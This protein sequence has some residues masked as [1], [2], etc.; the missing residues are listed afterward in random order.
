MAVTTPKGYI[1]FDC[2][3]SNIKLFRD[4]VDAATAAAGAN[5]ADDII[6]EFYKDIVRAHD[7]KLVFKRVIWPKEVTPPAT[8][9]S[10]V[11]WL[12]FKNASNAIFAIYQ[13]SLKNILS[14]DDEMLLLRFFADLLKD[15]AVAKIKLPMGGAK[16]MIYRIIKDVFPQ[17]FKTQTL[18]ALLTILKG[19]WGFAD[20]PDPAAGEVITQGIS[21]SGDHKFKLPDEL[22]VMKLIFRDSG[23]NATEVFDD[24]FNLH[25]EKSKNKRDIAVEQLNEEMVINVLNGIAIGSGPAGQKLFIRG[26]ESSLDPA[27]NPNKGHLCLC[28]VDYEPDFLSK[29]NGVE[30]NKLSFN[31]STNRIKDDHFLCNVGILLKDENIGSQFSNILCDMRSLPENGGFGVSRNP[32]V[33]GKYGN[34]EGM[35]M[36]GYTPPGKRGGA[37]NNQ[38]NPNFI[39][40]FIMGIAG[41]GTKNERLLA[42]LN[43]VMTPIAHAE[44]L[45]SLTLKSWGDANQ[46]LYIISHVLYLAFR[47]LQNVL[48]GRAGPHPDAEGPPPSLH[49]FFMHTLS[50]C[51]IITCDSVLARTAVALKIPVVYQTGLVVSCINFTQSDPYN[52]ALCAFNSQRGKLLGIMD[53]VKFYLAKCGGFNSNLVDSDGI[54]SPILGN[55]DWFNFNIIR[56]RIATAI[57]THITET[58]NLEPPP[59]QITHT[60]DSFQPLIKSLEKIGALYKI[61]IVTHTRNRVHDGAERHYYNLDYLRA[62]LLVLSVGDKPF[63]VR[64][65]RCKTEPEAIAHIDY[66]QCLAAV[67]VLSPPPPPVSP[68][69]QSVPLPLPATGATAGMTQAFSPLHSAPLHSERYV[70]LLP[71]PTPPPTRPVTRSMAAVAAGK[72]NNNNDQYKTK[73]LPK[74]QIKQIIE[75]NIIKNEQIKSLS[76]PRSSSS[77]GGKRQNRV[78]QIGG[79]TINSD[80]IF[81]LLGS[82]YITENTDQPYVTLNIDGI[83]SLQ[84][85]INPEQPPYPNI[86]FL[87]VPFVHF[88]LLALLGSVDIDI[89]RILLR[90]LGSDEFDVDLQSIYDIVCEYISTLKKI[91]EDRTY[92]VNLSRFYSKMR[93]QRVETETAD[94]TVEAAVRGAAS[95]VAA[96]E[97]AGDVGRVEGGMLGVVV[98]KVHEILT[99]VAAEDRRDVEIV[100]MLLSELVNPEHEDAV[101]KQLCRLLS[102]GPVSEEA[103]T[104]KQI[105]TA[106]SISIGRPVIVEEGTRSAF[107][108]VPMH[109][110]VSGSASSHRADG[111]AN[112]GSPPDGHLDQSMSQS[113]DYTYTQP[114]ARF[115][116]PPES[117][118][119]SHASVSP[120]RSLETPEKLE[121]GIDYSLVL[122]KLYGFIIR[123]QYLKYAIMAGEGEDGDDM[124]DTGP[125]SQSLIAVLIYMKSNI[126]KTVLLNPLGIEG[127]NELCISQLERIV[128]SEAGILQEMQGL[129]RSDEDELERTEYNTYLREIKEFVAHIQKECK[130]AVD[131]GVDKSKI[132]FTFIRPIFSEIKRGQKGHR[133]PSSSP[134]PSSSSGQG[135]GPPS[136][137]SSPSSPSKPPAKKKGSG[138]A[139]AVDDTAAYAGG[140]GSC[141][142]TKRTKKYKRTPNKRNKTI[143]NKFK[144]KSSLRNTIKRRKT[145]QRK[146]SRR[147]NQ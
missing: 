118:V 10:F 103:I 136:S 95:V 123:G 48:R 19:G 52:I 42:L 49:F 100:N 20:P 56:A 138:A 3:E 54:P 29:W 8:H 91:Y 102:L 80:D 134:P 144:T 47:L 13:L 104:I 110:L 1:L 53:A 74:K 129:S 27:T 124:A 40:L 11:V 77:G 90:Y 87:D 2:A 120:P 125:D 21:S 147:R 130:I 137:P 81:A 72:I 36:L 146:N 18:D 83:P 70:E 141:N 65:Q 98:D 71:T 89:V 16:E 122:E 32:E 39:K 121:L 15:L 107:S 61:P 86:H 22:Q 92:N 50:K 101:I 114:D 43:R 30:P 94:P 68:Q 85:L 51:A 96:A 128:K 6:Q 115:L 35:H 140:G 111:P 14:F 84:E 59:P 31:L 12:C 139:A 97:L 9:S 58:L 17:M 116:L 4:Q 105:A 66:Q 135:R 145:K 23:P 28:D 113:G 41:N 64:T 57:D 79:A 75:T 109:L 76:R 24:F 26:P 143:R 55:V 46:L 69:L 142:N 132:P 99:S 126:E 112:D 78:N 38:S 33:V 82:D 37:Q 45:T 7:C 44:G 60:P 119:G 106:T 93:I 67:N 25:Y 88:W 127:F 131:S 133:T 34:S 108:V 73:F 63:T 5:P 62:L 117:D